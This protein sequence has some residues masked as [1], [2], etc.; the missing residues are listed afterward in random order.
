MILL[1]LGS[2][3]STLIIAVS[4]PLSILTSIIVLS[5]LGE[6]INIMTLGGLALAVG[7]L[8]DDATVAIENINWHL[9]QGK[10]LE[11]AIL[12]G[13]EQIA[14][15]AF[16]STLCICIVFV[17]MFFLTGVG[18]LPVRAA[19]RGR[20]LR[21]ARVVRPV[22]DAGA[23]DGEV[24]AEGARRRT[25]HGAPR[26]QSVRRASSARFDGGFVPAARRLS[27]RRSSV[28]A[29]AA[30]LFSPVF[31][32]ACVLSFAAAALA[33]ARTSSRRST[34]ASSSCT[35]ARRPAPASRKRRVLSDASS[36]AIR[37]VI[38]ADEIGSIIDNIGLPYSGLNLAYSNSA[39]IGAGDADILVALAEIIGRPPDYVRDLRLRLGRGSPACSSRSSPADI[40]SQI[41]NFGLPAPIDVQIVGRNSDANRQFA[42]ELRQLGQVPGHRRPARPPGGEPAVA[43]ARTSTAR[44]PRS[45]ASRS[46]TSPTT[47]SSR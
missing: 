44:G 41:L 12:D 25:T 42:G 47:C 10:A 27:A 23:D 26:A 4:I 6:T 2:W 17:P 14:M 22:A 30:R 40:V 3:R 13:A 24:P 38:P 32:L 7:I 43:A 11:P 39:P 18:A 36:S 1:F 15:P 5:A 29:S 35:C 33:S 46:A 21:D 19:G 34:A 31:L 45:P 20:R 37:E 8:V 9:E 16:V 28:P